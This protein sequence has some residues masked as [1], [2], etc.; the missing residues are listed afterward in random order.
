MVSFDVRRR[1]L[2]MAGA[3]A[4]LAL[5]LSATSIAQPA[6]QQ[7][8]VAS[9]QDEIRETQLR[10]GEHSPALI[11][12]LTALGLVYQ[13]TREPLLAATALR[14][15]VQVVRVNYGLHSLE[16]APLIRQMIANAE[17]IGDHRTA[18]DLEQDLLRL[19]A[20]HPDDPRT[21]EIL[22][23]TGD[24]RMDLLARYNAGERPPEIVFGCYYQPSRTAQDVGDVAHEKNCAA[25][26]SHIV[27]EGL[28]NEAQA[29]YVQ[30]V[31]IILRSEH[32]SS[33]ELPGLLMDLVRTSYQYGNS[34]LGRRSL[35][36]VLAYEASNN[37][38]DWSTRVEAL[39][40]I[41]DWDLLHAVGRD[42]K[43]SA[44]EEYA[45]AY[46]LLVQQGIA[47]ETIDR[48]FAPATPVVLPAFLPNPLVT[49]EAQASTYIDVAFDVDRYGGG[50]HVRI[51]GTSQLPDGTDDAARL[52]ERRLVQ[53]IS[54]AR[55]RPKLADGRA[56]D[57][58]PTIV[59][60][61]FN[62]LDAA[63]PHWSLYWA[64][65]EASRRGESVGWR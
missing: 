31:D 61:Y 18:W 1:G 57:T 32:Y 65:A 12:P 42:D 34:S 27:R 19:A 9:L 17:S 64:P 7:Q 40:Q 41:A 43:E 52:V 53:L 16:Q 58:A 48:M 44:L 30:A 33:D 6:A 54:R 45:R 23:Y 3:P 50:R 35:S 63:E 55:F 15:A 10:D 39:V 56:A 36:Y 38:D 46:Q 22:R 47:Q 24:R 28:L 13:E 11:G 8:T 62:A 25:G 21:A 59:R 29:Y 60:Y 26:A 14:E 4:I 51:L 20:R 49:E 5:A 2:Q 37:S